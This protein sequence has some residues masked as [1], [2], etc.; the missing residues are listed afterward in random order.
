MKVVTSAL[1]SQR[2]VVQPIPIVIIVF[3]NNLEN[4][5]ETVL[6]KGPTLTKPS[7]YQLS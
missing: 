1:K 3:C 5:G 2:N 7:T 6:G 4:Y